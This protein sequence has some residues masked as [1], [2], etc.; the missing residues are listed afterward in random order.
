MLLNRN[1]K[2]LVK[3][4][5]YTRRCCGVVLTLILEFSLSFFWCLLPWGNFFLPESSGIQVQSLL[6]T[7]A[8]IGFSKT[9]LCPCWSVYLLKK[10]ICCRPT[11]LV[12]FYLDKNFAL[13]LYLHCC[14]CGSPQYL[15]VGRRGN[16]SFVNKAMG[17][18]LKVSYD[19]LKN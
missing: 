4:T 7:L 12:G 8:F 18:L 13:L 15:R 1:L 17:L 19:V 10:L 6:H 9:L 2:L 11:Y 5:V 3:Y 16:N 14:F